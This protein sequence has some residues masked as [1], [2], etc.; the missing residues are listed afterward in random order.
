MEKQVDVVVVGAG[1]VGLL[2]AIELSLGGVRGLV[3]ERLAAPS[4]AMK[5]GG[6]GPLGSE[7]SRDF[8]SEVKALLA[9]FDLGKGQRRERGPQSRY[10]LSRFPPRST[11][12][13]FRVAA[14]FACRIPSSVTGAAQTSP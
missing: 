4:L 1:P 7:A 12:W 8:Y 11:T 14:R 10:C 6:I 3:L 9:E 2:T 5:A 13:T